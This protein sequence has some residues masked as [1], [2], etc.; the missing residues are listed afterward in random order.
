[1]PKI[2]KSPKATYLDKLAKLLEQRMPFA[3][4]GGAVEKVYGKKWGRPVGERFPEFDYYDRGV[5]DPPIGWDFLIGY[6]RGYG[7][8]LHFIEDEPGFWDIYPENEMVSETKTQGFVPRRVPR[9]DMNAF[10]DAIYE[11]SL[12]HY[13]EYMKKGVEEWNKM[14]EP[15]PYPQLYWPKD[16]PNPTE[17]EFMEWR[18]GDMRRSNNP[19]LDYFERRAQRDWNSYIREEAAKKKIKRF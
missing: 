5:G 11:E 14:I 10:A 4:R 19:D 7:K 16:R 12:K 8:N 15:N 9:D 2:V 17:E 6:P 1:M 18:L 3:H 13:P